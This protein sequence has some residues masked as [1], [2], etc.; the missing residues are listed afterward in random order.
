MFKVEELQKHK[1]DNVLN[2]IHS[3]KRIKLMQSI[4]MPI[5]FYKI[6]S[7]LILFYFLAFFDNRVG[8]DGEMATFRKKKFKEAVRYKINNM[9]KGVTCKGEN[10]NETLELEPPRKKKRSN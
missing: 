5:C 3:T 1:R 7:N 8:N 2:Y 6:G 9:L 4:A 10:K